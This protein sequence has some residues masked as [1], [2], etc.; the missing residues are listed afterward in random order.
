MLQDI[1]LATRQL[2]KNPGFGVVAV[3]MLALAIG[4]NSTIFSA[5]DAVLLHP[6]PYPNASRLMV[7]TENFPHYRLTGSPP[8]FAEFLECESS[9]CHK[10]LR[11]WIVRCLFIRSRLNSA[12]KLLK[13]D[14]QMKLAQPPKELAGHEQIPVNDLRL[15][16]TGSSDARS[17]QRTRGPSETRTNAD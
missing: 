17:R 13:H 4:A 10:A 2:W 1:R 7:V 6:L 11:K 15:L 5:V 16:A 9:G 3:L 14:R 8:S 12:L